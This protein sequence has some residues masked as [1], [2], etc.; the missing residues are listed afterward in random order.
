MGRTNET[1]DILVSVSDKEFII[2]KIRS[3]YVENECEV[4]DKLKKLD[5]KVKRPASIC[6]YILGGVSAFIII[7]GMSLAMT[8]IGSE[9]YIINPEIPGIII[10]ILGV[11]I[12]YMNY[13]IYEDSLAAR[14][15]QYRK[16]IIKLCDEIM[17]EEENTSLS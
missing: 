5:A 16:Q 15:Y 3:Q 12:S 10:S 9:M 13:L 6:A 4:I 8:D 1:G 11:A 17:A 14:R 7:C 2:Q